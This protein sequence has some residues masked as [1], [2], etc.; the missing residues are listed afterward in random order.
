MDFAVCQLPTPSTSSCPRALQLI[1][2]VVVVVLFL[3][4]CVYVFAFSIT[5]S[6]KLSYKAVVIMLVCPV[7][8]VEFAVVNLMPVNM[9]P[10]ASLVCVYRIVA[11]L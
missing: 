6:D 3:S 9:T 4:L 11:F 10:T 7:H 5:A 8:S 2:Y 1:Y